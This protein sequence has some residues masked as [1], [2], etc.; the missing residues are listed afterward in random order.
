MQFDSR[1]SKASIRQFLKKEREEAMFEYII[2]RTKQVAI[3]P[4]EYCG[5]AKVIKT[6]HGKKR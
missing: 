1:L 5:N 2:T 4:L 3:G 6:S